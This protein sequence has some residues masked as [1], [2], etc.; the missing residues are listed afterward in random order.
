MT[1]LMAIIRSFAASHY[2][3]KL[4]G[5]RS[6][7][8]RDIEKS[9]EPDSGLLK[10]LPDD[11]LIRSEIAAHSTWSGRMGMSGPSVRTTSAR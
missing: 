6:V 5:A 11:R 8:K 1:F 10:L 7:G 2:H 9:C 4:P 3:G